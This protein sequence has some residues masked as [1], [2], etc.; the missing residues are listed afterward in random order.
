MQIPQ[1]YRPKLIYCAIAL[2]LAGCGGAQPPIGSANPMPQRIVGSSKP[3]APTALLYVTN[4]GDYDEVKVYDARAKDPNPIE[5]ISS[6]METPFGDCFDSKGTL[7]VVNEPAGP[8]WI[9]EF[10]AGKT[11]PSR[12]I[13]KGINTPA[14]CAIDSKDDL[15]VTNISNVNAAEYESGSTKPHAAI[16]KGMVY[17]VGIAFD[18]AGNMYVSNRLS[19]YSGNVEVYPPGSKSPKRTIT[20]GV[21]SPVG[22]TVDA[23]GTLYVVNI[24]ESDVEEYRFGQSHPFQAITEALNGP[25]A[26][27]VSKDGYLYVTNTGGNNVLE[28]APGSIKPLGR[29]INKDLWDA[30]AAAY[31]PALLP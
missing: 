17:P 8:G 31:S 12:I 18:H 21:T 30:E 19:E 22:I 28:F 15:W 25:Q 16:T 29:Q 26:V 13:T 2:I 1:S 5:V 11:K 24:I 3:H 6:D 4:G 9:T 23:K 27:T 14:F 20:N 7:Y 10:P